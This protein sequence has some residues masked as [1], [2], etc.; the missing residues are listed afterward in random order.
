MAVNT[1]N[2]IA[3]TGHRPPRLGLSYSR[4]DL[5]RLTKFA[6]T[7]L[8]S[9]ADYAL[10]ELSIISGM[11]LGWDQA[12]ASAAIALDLV[13]ICAIPFEGQEGK[14]PKAA[15]DFYTLI[16]NHASRVVC[17]GSKNNITVAFHSRD[18]WM[19]DNAA[20]M[21]ALYNGGA[22]GGTFNTL[23]YAKKKQKQVTNLWRAWQS[24][25]SVK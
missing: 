19:V 3:G 10:G 8:K 13:F 23:E 20:E 7:Y 22:Y 12:L 6:I 14:W 16:I 9:R 2:V 15:Q 4:S 17:V 1:S 21:L 5:D 24:Y 11:A 25:R 18:R